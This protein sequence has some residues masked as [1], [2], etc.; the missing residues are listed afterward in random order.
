MTEPVWRI[1]SI[2]GLEKYIDRFLTLAYLSF[3]HIYV[4]DNRKSNDYSVHGHVIYI[5]FTLCI[6]EFSIT[7]NKAVD[8]DSNI[9]HFDVYKADIWNI[10]K[11]TTA[12]SKH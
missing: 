7:Y 12:E 2:L 6:V 8:N 5:F 9:C 4:S 10:E 1:L 11:I 3:L